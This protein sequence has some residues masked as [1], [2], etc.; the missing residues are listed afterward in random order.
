M[1]VIKDVFHACHPFLVD[2]Q[3][4]AVYI[5]AKRKNNL[6]IRIAGSSCRPQYYAYTCTWMHEYRIILIKKKHF[7][8]VLPCGLK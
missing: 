4:T 8:G 5:H 7:P 6:E 1:H 3:M 2:V